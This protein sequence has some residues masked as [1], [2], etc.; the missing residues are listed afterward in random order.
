MG[1]KWSNEENIKCE[2]HFTFPEKGFKNDLVGHGQ[3]VSL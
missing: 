3:A 2:E 1:N